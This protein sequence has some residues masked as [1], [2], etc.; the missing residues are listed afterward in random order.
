MITIEKSKS[1]PN[2]KNI[3]WV[4]TS[5]NP[6]L[7]KVCVNGDWTIIGTEKNTEELESI[8]ESLKLLSDAQKYTAELTKILKSGKEG[9]I[10]MSDGKGSIYWDYLETETKAEE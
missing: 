9:Q 7:L 10:L 2:N 5:V 8:K 1:T 6:P 3:L 4:D